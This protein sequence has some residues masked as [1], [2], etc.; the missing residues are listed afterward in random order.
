MFLEYDW[1]FN[2]FR[3]RFGNTFIAVRGE[4]SWPSMAEAK[5]ALADAK[6]K[7][8]HKTDSRTW[9]IDNV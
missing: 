8:G 3:P 4:R 9:A 7:V 6:L 5:A 1:T 2:C